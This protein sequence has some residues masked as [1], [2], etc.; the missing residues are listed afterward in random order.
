MKIAALLL[1]TMTWPECG[2]ALWCHRYCEQK[3]GSSGKVVDGRGITENGQSCVCVVHVLLPVQ[4]EQGVS[5]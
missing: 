3:L 1:F 2:D 4:P 5:K